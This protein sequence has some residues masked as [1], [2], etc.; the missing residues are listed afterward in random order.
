MNLLVDLILL[1]LLI[2]VTVLI[3]ELGHFLFAKLTD[4]DVNEFS[5]GIG[6]KIWNTKS[7]KSE[8]K[9]SIRMIPLGGYCSFAKEEAKKTTNKKKLN[10]K[11][12]WQKV[13]VILMGPIFNLTFAITILL[14]IVLV[15]GVPSSNTKILSI[16]KNSPAYNVGLDKGDIITEI[17]DS[18]VKNIN[19]I[20]LY[21]IF[22]DKNTIKIKV[23]KESGLYHTYRIKEINKNKQNQNPLGI[24]FKIKKEYD[25]GKKL[26]S[27]FPTTKMLI[28]QMF[29]TTKYI[30]TGRMTAHHLNGPISIY[31]SIG[32]ESKNNILNILYLIV[33]LNINISILTLL[34]LPYFDG[35][36]I[37]SM[38]T[39]KEKISSN[40]KRN[41]KHIINFWLLILLVLFITINDV[42]RLF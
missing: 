41:K 7:K 28:R 29:M 4:I 27:V 38:I 10:S 22:N 36:N 3:H 17:N 24:K 19:D 35:G 21:L 26:Q 40:Y 16:E 37:L 30:L 42:I 34:P 14:M 6:P 8:T 13:L 11:K 9:Y 5:V 1:I 12:G 25:R 32:I 23:K 33:Y 15:W 18:K 20:S 2:G 39:T 31:S